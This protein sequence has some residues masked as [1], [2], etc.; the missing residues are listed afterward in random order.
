[1]GG[2][3]KMWTG[4]IHSTTRATLKKWPYVP[5]YKFICVGLR[6]KSC[7]F[8]KIFF[9]FLKTWILGIP[10]TRSIWFWWFLLW[11]G[12]DENQK[13]NLVKFWISRNMIGCSSIPGFSRDMRFSGFY[14]FYRAGQERLPAK[15]N[16]TH[17]KT[18]HLNKRT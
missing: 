17:Y 10:K 2:F 14:S 6:Q 1:M 11:T 4:T 9:Y 13:F 5:V 16:R 18:M 8:T 3:K 15:Y 12:I 7:D